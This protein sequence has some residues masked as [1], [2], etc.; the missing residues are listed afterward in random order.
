MSFLNAAFNSITA[1]RVY[2]ALSAGL[3]G[4]S[5]DTSAGRSSDTVI[6]FPSSNTEVPKSSVSNVSAGTSAKPSTSTQNS[7]QQTKIKTSTKSSNKTTTSVSSGKTKSHT[8]A[9]HVSVSEKPIKPEIK[10][11]TTAPTTIKNP[12]KTET[13]MTTTRR[14]VSESTIKPE[15]KTASGKTYFPYTDYLTRN[16]GSNIVSTANKYIGYNEYDN[17]YK[18]FTN[19]R[20][21]A[22]CADFV[23]YTVK[24]AYGKSGKKVPFWF[25][26]PS[27]QT[28][29]DNA[30]SN[31]AFLNTRLSSNKSSLICGNVKPGDIVIFKNNRSHTGIVKEVYPD[32]SFKTIEG[33]TKGNDVAYRTYSANESTLSGFIQL[34]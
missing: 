24:E 13:K 23:T 5:A 26:S 2:P 4:Q 22:W 32:G 1:E 21:E 15:S 34:A 25:G 27:V 7:S 6:R 9:V 14:T 17:S 11:T 16:L 12:I 33:N 31:G 8:A 18:L 29:M 19:G 20:N 10:I 3:G 28:L 30:K